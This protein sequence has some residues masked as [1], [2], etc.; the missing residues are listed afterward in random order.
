VKAISDRSL[1]GN[2]R[3]VRIIRAE[4][5]VCIGDIID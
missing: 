5:G 4:D 2:V 3:R 1:Q